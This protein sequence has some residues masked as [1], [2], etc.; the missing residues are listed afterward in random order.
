[1]LPTLAGAEIGVAST[2][3]FT[4]QLS[5]LLALSIR[6]ARSNRLIDAAGESELIDALERLPQT[7]RDYLEDDTA[8]NR[9]ARKLRRAR[10]MIYLGR[11][12]AYP[13]ALEGALKLKEISYIQAEAYPAGE[14]KHGP[15]ALI[16]D[17]MPV[18]V[19]AP[20]GPLFD[21]SLSNL[22][23]VAARGGRVILLSDQAGV[24]AAAE[25]IDDAIVM[26]EVEQ[27]LQPILYSL[28]LQMLAY[29]VAVLKGTD[30]DQPRNLAKSVTVE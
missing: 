18:L 14:L 5:V 21:K 13:L 6:V 28:P 10:Q 19:I 3:A 26:P 17:K 22:R 23:E 9:I 24:D 4:A 25:F 29:Q 20:P 12:I 8:I 27:P 1:M 16:D 15:I 7:M 30:V 2:K 11:G